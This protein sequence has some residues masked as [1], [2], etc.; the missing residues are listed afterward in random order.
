[1]EATVKDLIDAVTKEAEAMTNK[2]VAVS[3]RETAY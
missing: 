3:R 1:L 2:V